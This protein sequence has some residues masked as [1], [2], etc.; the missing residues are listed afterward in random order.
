MQTT[1]TTDDGDPVTVNDGGEEFVEASTRDGGDEGSTGAGRQRDDD[2]DVRKPQLY[3]DPRRAALYEKY[4]RER[5]AENAAADARPTTMG[6]LPPALNDPRN[7]VP[8]END[9]GA[10]PD[11]GDP[12]DGQHR[13]NEDQGAAQKAAPS[14]LSLR[15]NGADIQLSR[16]DAMKAAGIE[17]DEAGDYNDLQII[18]LAQK[19]IAADQRL[20]E[21]RNSA[22]AVSAD[23]TATPTGQ[24]QPTAPQ[25][26]QD[27]QHQGEEMD[28]D[29][30]AILAEK[31]QFEDPAEAG[32][33][34]SKFVEKQIQEGVKRALSQQ[35]IETR[36]TAVL[37]EIDD[38]IRQT[39]EDNSDIADDWA[40][41]TLVRERAVE[42]AVAELAK[43]GATPQE[44]EALRRNGT[45]QQAYAAA[46]AHG[47]QVP[48][49]TELFNRAVTEVRQVLNRPAPARQ[50]QQ[51]QQ[52]VNLTRDRVAE[53]R[54]L[55]TPP[56]QSTSQTT[57]RTAPRM[58]VEQERRLAFAEMR[59][60]RASK[61]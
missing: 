57:A 54:T 18:K 58:S 35:T 46:R 36:Q 19:H 51:Q 1:Q 10:P 17:P 50:Q 6:H 44:I 21:I 3:E 16:E 24:Q 59:E 5:E 39:V 42:E 29:E 14:L 45:V 60:H 48:P 53:K 34:L 15:V 4:D 40:A 9:L 43:I 27:A 61:R 52:G 37:S 30:A 55:V 32:K 2:G 8:D 7:E 11:T 20:Q 22:R 49:A 47:Y 23:A 26:T 41:A 12:G 38:A 25:Q 13:Q 56:A 28:A 31:L 33:H